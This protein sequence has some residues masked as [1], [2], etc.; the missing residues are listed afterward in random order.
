[1]KLMYHVEKC[2]QKYWGIK[3][4]KAKFC[5]NREKKSD[6]TES[7]NKNVMVE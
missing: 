4:D 7:E 6:D 3:I 5:E 2:F 1:M